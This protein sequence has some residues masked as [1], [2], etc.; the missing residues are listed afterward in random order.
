MSSG[1]TAFTLALVTKHDRLCAV[2]LRKA[3]LFRKGALAALDQGDPR[4]C[5]G[6]G[7]GRND[8]GRGAGVGVDCAG[9][10]DQVEVT[11]E[12]FV[13][14]VRAERR[15]PRRVERVGALSGRRA[16]SSVGIVHQSGEGILTST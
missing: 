7:H 10:L 16:R 6:D 8:C 2:M 4:R 15:R 9:V 1:D 13:E 12:G 5:R 11:A 3:N 14:D